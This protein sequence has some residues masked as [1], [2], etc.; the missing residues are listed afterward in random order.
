MLS[1]K[2]KT[3]II[4]NSLKRHSNP[5]QFMNRIKISS[6]SALK[7]LTLLA[8]SLDEKQLEDF[9]PPEKIEPFIV[10]LMRPEMRKKKKIQINQSRIFFLGYMLL[11]WSLN[12]TGSTL[13]NKWAKK[14]YQ[15]HEEP[16]RDI[17]D[18]LYHERKRQVE[19]NI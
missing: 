15:Q 14:I 9:F 13:N 6:D 8:E 18:S 12:T 3:R 16:L 4:N 10:A 11:T 5:S 19:H 1:K 17:L 7:D 2:S